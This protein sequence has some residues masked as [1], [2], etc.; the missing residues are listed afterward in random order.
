MNEVQFDRKELTLD[1]DVVLAT[2]AFTERGRP[3]LVR[4]PKGS[5]PARGEI[6]IEADTGVVRRTTFELSQDGFKVKLSTEYA[7][8]KAL[9]LW[10]PAVLAERYETDADVHEVVVAQATYTNYRRFDVTA[11]IR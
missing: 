8:D 11:R 10:L 7:W 2:L 6:V 1:G 4:G 5:M 3:T 9:G